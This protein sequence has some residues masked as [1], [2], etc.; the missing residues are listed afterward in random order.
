MSD[1]SFTAL[2]PEVRSTVTDDARFPI[3]YVS[4]PAALAPEMLKVQDTIAICPSIASQKVALGALAA[5]RG[6]VSQ[7]VAGLAEQKAL[8]LAA[9]APLGDGAVQGG[10]GAIYLV[11]RLPPHA[12]DDVAA[13]RTLAEEH[14]V[15]LIPG[16]ACGAPGHIRICYANL[17]LE[18]TREAAA[19][20]R[21]GLQALVDGGAGRRA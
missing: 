5:G 1:A 3:R 15:A 13:V 21:R 8:V 20:L 7:R 2:A 16:S 4:F 6:W 11:A 14:G 19:R 12:A 10:S 18:Q 9:L 17:P